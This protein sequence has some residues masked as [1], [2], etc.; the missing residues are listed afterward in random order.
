MSSVLGNDRVW[1]NRRRGSTRRDRLHPHVILSMGVTWPYTL[2]LARRWRRITS[3]GQWVPWGRVRLY[4]VPL[5]WLVI[6]EA[7]GRFLGIWTN[8]TR[9]RPPLSRTPTP[10]DGVIVP[11]IVTHHAGFHPTLS[12]AKGVIPSTCGTRHPLLLGLTSPR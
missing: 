10:I 8:W 11:T 6:E 7:L 4:K 2:A 3:G 12:R 5:R 9:F 1:I